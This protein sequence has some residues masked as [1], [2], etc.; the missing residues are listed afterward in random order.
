V[1]NHTSTGPLN[2]DPRK[3][4]F[5]N[6][7][8]SSLVSRKKHVAEGGAVEGKMGEGEGEGDGGVGGLMRNV[9]LERGGKVG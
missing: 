5:P 4:E 1:P 2:F 3:A 6:R 8:R 7:S 9:D